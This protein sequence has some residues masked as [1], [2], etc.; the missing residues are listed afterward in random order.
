M[1]KVT[2]KLQVTIPRAIARAY[3]IAPGSLVTWEPAGPVIRV[4]PQGRAAEM[5]QLD[6]ETRLG[7]FDSA[8]KR[9]ERRNRKWTKPRGK[10]LTKRGW[11]REDLYQRGR[12]G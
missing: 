9:Q 12:S 3:R 6:L 11:S 10:P 4:V 5:P 2:S 8:M 7:L 1:S